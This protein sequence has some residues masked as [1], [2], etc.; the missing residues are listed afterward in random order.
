[1]GEI[2]QEVTDRIILAIK[3]GVPPRRAGWNRGELHQNLST[4]TSYKGIN[5]LLLVI[6]PY[7][8][9]WWMTFKQATLAGSRVKKGAHV[10]RI[11]KMVEV[12]LD[13]VNDGFDTEII[14]VE[15]KKALIMKAYTVFNA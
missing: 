4:G 12:M 14:G 6:A 10:I 7:A 2:R 5:A 8:D 3:T 13:R 15:G 11:I 9:P 1:M